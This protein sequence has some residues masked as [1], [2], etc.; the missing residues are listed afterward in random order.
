MNNYYVVFSI[1]N[2]LN[3]DVFVADAITIDTL[4]EWQQA[5][6]IEYKTTD[7]TIVN[8]KRID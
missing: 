1:H 6:M 4:L 7:V 8:W 5:L 2:S 3:S